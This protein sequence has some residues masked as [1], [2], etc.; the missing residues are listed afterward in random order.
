[1]DGLNG[2]NSQMLGG[3]NEE[4]CR[5]GITGRERD[6]E[7]CQRRDWSERGL[8]DGVNMTSL[9]E[10]KGTYESY[11]SERRTGNDAGVCELE[12]GSARG[13]RTGMVGRSTV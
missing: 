10:A 2:T 4:Q 11:E 13:S 8:C 5:F 3:L 7:T 12:E 6:Y 9:K 1:M